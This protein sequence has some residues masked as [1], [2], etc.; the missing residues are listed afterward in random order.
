[1]KA[2]IT[3]IITL[4][5]SSVFGQEKTTL[6]VINT[7]TAQ[8]L[9]VLAWYSIPEPFTTAERFGELAETGIMPNTVRL[10]IVIE[11]V[12]DIIEDLAQALG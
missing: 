6:R 3:V 11:H 9:P 1:M 8:I 4:L 5:C 2:L 12:D 10:S 7:D